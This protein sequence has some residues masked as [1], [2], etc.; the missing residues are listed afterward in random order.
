[1]T[2]ERSEGVWADNITAVFYHIMHLYC[3]KP[4]NLYSTVLSAGFRDISN[5]NSV[6]N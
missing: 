1:M 5:L 2:P 4:F 3:S 6:E